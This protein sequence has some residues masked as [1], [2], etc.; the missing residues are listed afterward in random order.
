MPT[1]PLFPGTA[2][3][4]TYANGTDSTTSTWECVC[5]RERDKG[6]NRKEK[7]EQCEQTHKLL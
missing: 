1:F 2:L 6:K 3:F 4:L 7:G 5:V